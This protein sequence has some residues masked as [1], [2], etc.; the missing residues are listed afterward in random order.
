MSFNQDWSQS[1]FSHCVSDLRLYALGNS[2]N[3][4]SV[5]T[6]EHFIEVYVALVSLM[7]YPDSGTYIKK[8]SD[9]SESDWETM[10]YITEYAFFVNEP[11]NYFDKNED[12]IIFELS[13]YIQ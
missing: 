4:S 3:N 12:G 10:H 8:I 5:E 13:Y 1:F 6:E 2:T 9:I 7:A 11:N